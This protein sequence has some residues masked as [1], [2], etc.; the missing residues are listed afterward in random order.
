[1]LF[2]SEGGLRVVMIPDWFQCNTATNQ[3]GAWINSKYRSINKLQ[4]KYG[5]TYASMQRGGNIIE[6]FW[7]QFQSTWQGQKH[8]SGHQDQRS[9]MKESWVAPWSGSGPSCWHCS[10]CWCTSSSSETSSNQLRMVKNIYLDTKN[11]L[12]RCQG[13]ELHLEVALDHV[14][15][16]VVGVGVH[17][18]VLKPVPIN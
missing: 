8:I 1:M 4:C 11:N 15:G 18:S 16:I 10:W 17:W 9:S 14:V 13:A 7:N 2:I 5:L 6:Q 3:D 12:L